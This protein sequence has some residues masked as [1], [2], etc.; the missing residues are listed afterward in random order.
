M[1]RFIPVFLLCAILATGTGWTTP[2]AAAIDEDSLISEQSDR[3]STTL[4]SYSADVVCYTPGQ[5]TVSYNVS[6]KSLASKIGV[7]KI[8]I[9]NTSGRRLIT[10]TG[11]TSNGMMTT[12][13]INFGGNKAI[14]VASGTTCYAVVEFYASTSSGSDTTT[15]QT[16]NI[17]IP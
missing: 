3:A 15:F 9:Y 11:S 7:S 2:Q 13:A 14:S 16:T 4:S 6:S 10:V 12:N 17:T 8:H 1:K 5:V